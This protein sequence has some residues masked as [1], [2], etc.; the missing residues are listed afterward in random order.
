MIKSCI[1]CGDE[2]K[3]SPSDKKITCGA[4]ACVAERRR[5]SHVGKRNA[6]SDE[7]RWELAAKGKTANLQKGTAAARVSPIAGP[8]ETNRNALTWTL[9]APDGQ[10]Y[11]VRNLN[12]WL[13]NNAPLLDGTPEQARAGIM[14]MKRSVE[15]KTK[16]AVS[17]WKG[18]RLIKY[19]KLDE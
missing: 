8:F 16:R 9:E 6:W 17:Q 13:K 14:Q 7:S 5:L 4:A 19:E 15:G 12:L 18:W 10:R 2:F 11:T 3:C 1:V